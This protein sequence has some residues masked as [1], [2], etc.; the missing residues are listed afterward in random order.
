MSMEKT[1]IWK[2]SKFLKALF[3]SL[4]ILSKMFKENDDYSSRSPLYATNGVCSSSQPLA[5][6][7]GIDILKRGGNAADAAVAMAAVMNLTQPCSTGIGGDCFMI[8]YDAKTKEIHGMNG[9]G[10]APEALTL[11]L[12]KEKG[13]TG[14]CLPPYSALTVTVPGAAAA[15]CDTIE[16]FGSGKLTMTDILTPAIE[17]CELGV[18][19]Q[20]KTSMWWEASM[21]QLMT[22]PHSSELLINGQPPKPG[23]IFK[24]P[25]LAKTFKLL[26]SKGKDGFYK[27]EIANEIV[28]VIKELGGVLS[29]KD[30]EN[31]KTTFDKPIHINYRGY[32]IFEIPPNGQGITALLALNLLEEYK[33]SEMNPYSKEHLHLLIESLRISFSDTRYYV[34]DPAFYDAPLDKMLSKEYAR[35]RRKLVDKEK[36]NKNVEKGY[37]AN[38]SNTIYLTAV[39]RD[40]NACSFINSNYMSFGTGIIPKGCGFTLQNR[41]ANFSLDPSHPNSLQPNKRPYHTII[42]GMILKDGQLFASFGSMGGFIQPQSHVQLIVNLIDHKMDPQAA[43]NFPKFMISD[44]ESNGRIIFEDGHQEENIKGLEKMG[45]NVQL[46]PVKGHDRRIFGNGQII[47][48]LT[49]ENQNRIYCSGTDNRCDGISSIY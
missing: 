33:L 3:F 21:D 18:P 8:Y 40:G 49:D 47:V 30:L 26:A 36:C 16:K 15:W 48:Q 6:Q 31:H 13:I 10:R 5:S 38:S 34:A 28:K 45:H 37:P 24:N 4:Y 9:S 41:G 22:G 20:S 35:E 29:L 12:V 17:Y 39:D 46:G 2:T 25:N 7:V 32:D 23:Q 27:G 43:I 19:I 42:P 11:Q 14:D 1:S 44:G